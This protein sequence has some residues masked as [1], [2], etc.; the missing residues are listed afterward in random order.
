MRFLIAALILL[1]S[2]SASAEP[3]KELASLAP[4]TGKT[5]R[6]IDGS[7]DGSDNFVDTSK[8]EWILH[9]RV[10]RI[11]HSIG[12]GSYAGESLIHWDDV[13]GKI[14][15]R[16]VTTAGFYTDGVITPVEN[17]IEVHEFVRGSKSGPT[18][19][20]SAYRIEDGRMHGWSKL[21]IGGVW[22]EANE[23]VYEETPDAVP[24]IK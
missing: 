6:T 18:E 13:Q 16:Y 7:V 1:V 24:N 2:A 19:T 9:G 3:I 5:W 23:F 12:D 15:Y 14:I 20:L 21:L 4:F 17:G 22:G 11:T 8:W 10:V